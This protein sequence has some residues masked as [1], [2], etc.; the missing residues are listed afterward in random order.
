MARERLAARRK[1]KAAE[2]EKEMKEK[3]DE[4]L[5]DISDKGNLVALQVRKVDVK[6]VV[7]SVYQMSCDF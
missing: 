2:L 7:H 3:E 5:D 6:C 1:K 4:Q